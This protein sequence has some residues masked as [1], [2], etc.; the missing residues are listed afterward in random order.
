MD[1]D[2][3]HTCYFSKLPCY[4]IVE[5][6]VEAKQEIILDKDYTKRYVKKVI[7]VSYYRSAIQI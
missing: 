5:K 2:Q 6:L 1:D 3:K 4:Y 7:A